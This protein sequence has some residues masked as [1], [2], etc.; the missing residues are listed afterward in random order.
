MDA[1][2]EIYFEMGDLERACEAARFPIAHFSD[3]WTLELEKKLNCGKQMGRQ[4][5]KN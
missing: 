3:A 1:I 4:M 5:Q 2:E